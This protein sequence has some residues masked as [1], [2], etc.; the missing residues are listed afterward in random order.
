[1][2]IITKVLYYMYLQGLS[3]WLGSLSVDINNIT[4]VAIIFNT[5]MMHKTD[6]QVS[7]FRPNQ[8]ESVPV[9]WKVCLYFLLG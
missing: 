9:K 8:N 6:Y 1:M 5:D 2:C 4:Q 3:F 7:S